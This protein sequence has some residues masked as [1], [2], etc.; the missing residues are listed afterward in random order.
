MLFSE[1]ETYNE[2]RAFPKLAFRTDRSPMELDQFMHQ[3]EP[4]TASLMCPAP[5]ILNAVK[6]FEDA[7]H[8]LGRDTHT[9]IPN[10]QFGA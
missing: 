10:S 1:G 8:F 7:R 4:N 2:D 6:T 5:G 3:R 9:S